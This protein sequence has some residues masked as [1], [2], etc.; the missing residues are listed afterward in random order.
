MQAL[1]LKII[2]SGIIYSFLK[3]IVGVKFDKATFLL[4][5]KQFVIVANHNSHIDTMALMASLPSSIIHKVKP[6]AAADYFGKTKLKAWF[7]NYFINTLLISRK[8]GN[9]IH[10]MKKALEDG[11]SLIIFPEGSRGEPDSEQQMKAGVAL[12]LSLCPGVKYVPAYMYGMGRIMPKGD[13]L[14]VPFSSTLVYGKPTLPNS[15][16]VK[17]ILTQIK[18]DVDKLKREETYC[19]K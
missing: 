14:I 17:E 7:S 1:V 10:A 5:E 16:E 2:Y 4:Q 12:L 18:N 19:R 9:A 8:G 13:G 6:V 11:Y 3:L 15:D